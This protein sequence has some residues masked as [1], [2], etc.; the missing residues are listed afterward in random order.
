[1]YK[2]IYILLISA[3]IICC[4]NKP[5]ECNTA[6]L[7]IENRW[8]EFNGGIKNLNIK[9]RNDIIFICKKINQFSEGEEVMVNYNYGYITIFINNQKIDM[10]FTVKNGVV[11]NVGVGKYVYDEELTNRIMKLMKINNRQ[12]RVGNL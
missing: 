4:K 5:K 1:M 3:F 8:Y 7:Q 12:W 2:F 11:Y 10:I 6:E 9:N